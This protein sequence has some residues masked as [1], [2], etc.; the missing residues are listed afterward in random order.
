MA[1]T[2]V[3]CEYRKKENDRV[4]FTSGAFVIENTSCNIFLFYVGGADMY[5]Q[6]YSSPQKKN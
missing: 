2:H 4:E 6:G 1:L 5:P 3:L